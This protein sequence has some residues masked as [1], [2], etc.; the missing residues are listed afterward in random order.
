V[1][2]RVLPGHG[3][4][5]SLVVAKEA[6]RQRFEALLAKL[7][8]SSKVAGEIGSLLRR[9]TQKGLKSRRPPRICICPSSNFL[10]LTA[11]GG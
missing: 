3:V 11:N 10:D 9:R 2:R 5:V 4:A 6:D 8:E 7:A 1:V